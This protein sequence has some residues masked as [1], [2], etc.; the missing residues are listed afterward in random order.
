[1]L[2]AGGGGPGPGGPGPGGVPGL[3]GCLVWRGVVSHHALRQTPPPVNRM[4]NRCKNITLPQTPFAGGNNSLAAPS[5]EWTPPPGNP[6]S[7]TGIYIFRK[8]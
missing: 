5:F 7:A 6:G 3:G 1:M 8:M 4:T 2:C